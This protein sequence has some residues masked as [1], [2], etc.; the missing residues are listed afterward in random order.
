MVRIEIV[1]RQCIRC[2]CEMR[3][4]YDVKVEGAAYGRKITEQGIFQE[5]LGKVCAAVC[6][7]CGYLE[8]YLEDTAKIKK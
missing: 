7:V 1:M 6:P 4:H 2:K 8:F 5:N 3:E